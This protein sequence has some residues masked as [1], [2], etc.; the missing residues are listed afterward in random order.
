[1]DRKE[2]EQE[3]LTPPSQLSQSRQTI[4]HSYPRKKQRKSHGPRTTMTQIHEEPPEPDRR[5][6]I[7]L[8]QKSEESKSYKRKRTAV[9][10]AYDIAENKSPAMEQA[11]AIQSTLEA[12]FPSFAKA[13]VRSNVTVGFWMHL[14][15]RFCKMHLPRNDTTV[16]L[17]NENGEEFIT[18]YIAERTAL[19]GGW[20]A[21]CGANK[22]VEGDVL[23][24]H[25]LQ[26]LR[27]KVYV[28]K[29]N[30]SAKGEE[31]FGIAN[32]DEQEKI[33]ESDEAKE[34]IE[35]LKQAEPLEVLPLRLFQEKHEMSLVVSETNERHVANQSENDSKDNGC[36][37][38]ELIRSSGPD[39]SFK[40]IKGIENFSIIVNGMAIDSELSDHH[41]AKYYELCC[42]QASFLHENILS[43]MNQKLVAEIIVETV[44]VSDAIRTSKLSTSH[45][46]YAVWDKTLKG[47]ELL[48]MNVGFL[49]A[50]LNRLMSLAM[51]SEEAIET[52]CR[53]IRLE[54]ARVHEEME[55]LELK[56]L[57][58]KETRERLDAE[59]E[60]LKEDAESHE[61]KLHEMVNAPWRCLLGRSR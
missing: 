13:L 11:E 16:F 56:L 7:V 18:N 3:Q 30:D 20:K 35:S 43:S 40:D 12:E 21:F 22:L 42:S 53:E 37:I 19:S 50:R 45:A 38:L 5:T 46:D 26:P 48:G 33:I 29:G 61:L 15:M 31:E 60:I 51:E 36:K 4:T 58:L 28:V 55:N 52:E 32:L 23:I 9:R 27:F 14:P 10:E 25:L 2:E 24:F 39:D 54:Q 44:N 8:Y 57:S 34:D 59:I 49:R 6:Q 47:F 17:E 41:W 1:M